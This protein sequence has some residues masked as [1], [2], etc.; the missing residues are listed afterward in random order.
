MRIR[1]LQIL[2][3]P[4]GSE[5]DKLPKGKCP[6]GVGFEGEGPEGEGHEV[7]WFGGCVEVAGA[8]ESK[9]A[10][11]AKLIAKTLSPWEK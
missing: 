3:D 7:R 10:V 9:S 4:I 1:N 5:S 2:P 8:V 6:E 11:A